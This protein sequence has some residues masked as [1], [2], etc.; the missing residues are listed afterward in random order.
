MNT[1]KHRITFQKRLKMVKYITATL[2]V[3][4]VLTLASLTLAQ[5]DYYRTLS[6]NKRAK[7]IYVTASRGEIRDRNGLLLAGNKP[8]FTVQ[9]MKDEIDLKTKDE[10]NLAMT[11]LIHVLENDA[12]KYLNDFNIVLN[13]YEY[14][15]NSDYLKTDTSPFD[16]IVSIVQENELLPRILDKYYFSETDSGRFL[17]LPVKNAINALEFKS[18]EVPV[19]VDFDGGKVV[20]SFKE[21]VNLN[22][23]FKDHFMSPD[24][25]PKEV[26]IQLINEDQI[27]IIKKMMEHPITR[28]LIYEI[29]SESGLQENIVLTQYSYLFEQ[30]YLSA[31][32]TFMKANSEISMNSTAEQDFAVMFRKN[33]FKNLLIKDIGEEQDVI[34]VE[35]L[36]KIL[37]HDKLA[38]K[39]NFENASGVVVLTNEEEGIYDTEA[40]IDEIINITLHNNK[41][42]EFL[43][44]TGIPALAQSQMIEDGINTKISIANGY[45]YT[46]INGLNQ[47]L[48]DNKV[49]SGT[50][51]QDAFAQV[52][53]KY[54]LDES[55]SRYE[56]LG[57]LSIYNE[58][59]KQG[60]LAYV[61]INFA[62]GLK[63]ETVAK[64]E[65]QFSYFSGFN[66][67][68]EPVRYY[69]N[70]K[71][72]SHVLG[73]IGKISQSSEIE[74][75]VNQ[76]GYLPNALIGKTGIE[77]SFEKELNGTSGRKVVEVDSIGNT[78]QIL[79]ETQP[80]PGNNVYLSIDL[81]L[82]E[83]TEKILE[84]NLKT[85]Q[86][87]G[88]YYSEWGDYQVTTSK[89]KGR[90]YVNATSGAVIA[91]DVETGQVLSMA[92][93]PSYD[94]NLFAMGISNADWESLIPEDELNPLAPRPL[95]NVVTQTAI[96]PGS[97]FKMVTAL[98]ALEK[99]LSP[100]TT[101]DDAG[102]VEIGD[103]TFNCWLYKQQQQFHGR[104]NLYGALRD[105]CNYYFYT[106]ALGENQ[107]TGEKIEVKLEIEDITKTASDLGLGEK[108][109]M[110]I[111][112]PAE[113]ASGVPNPTTKTETTKSM[114]RRWLDNN[115]SKYYIGI[116]EFT[117]EKKQTLVNEI[118]G[119]IDL[120]YE[121]TRSEVV[122]DLMAMELEPEKRLGGLSEGL[123]DRIKFSYLN[124]AKWTIADTLNITIGQGENAYTLA[125][126]GNY[127]ATIANGGYKH[128]LSLI[129]NIK[130][131]NNSKTIHEQT[132]NSE[133]IDV[134][135]SNN[136]NHLMKG[137]HLASKSGLNKQV[138][139]DFP[140]DVGIKTGT[141]EKSGTNPI[142]GDTY[143]SYSYQVGFAPYDDPKIAVAVV[144]FQ[145]GD[146]S[147]C[148]PIVRDVIAEYMGLTKTEE[149][150][151]LPI[152]ME[153]TE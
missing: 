8:M 142:T 85:V 102:Y 80:I 44:L 78:T 131:Y 71:V 41:L 14:E 49:E 117:D 23:W 52:V 89:M 114:L 59:N 64:I 83:A 138:Y 152:E 97:T 48:K 82:Q 4:L 28:G 10:K 33:S 57:V 73:Y 146:G 112:I 12:V 45:E 103:H 115:I 15:D 47:W 65:E 30:E 106:L 5:G 7:N 100:E 3:I 36:L 34:P 123:A 21:D 77:E 116:E 42:E 74:T 56:K 121:L 54:D 76:R 35:E 27:T 50:S 109:G 140:I 141:A 136:F 38:E 70:G 90:P 137:M 104:E 95:Y 107:R 98:A 134:K 128:K 125:Q 149:T 127:V 81:K 17:Y 16:R 2:M 143:D 130:N 26:L 105:S 145:G 135:D 40:L 92:S 111:Y 25:P 13:S 108:T 58:I 68:V 72:A 110:E 93:Y 151:V 120:D 37:K 129:S 99:G 148:S 39:I 60:H 150:D 139:S 67:S 9:L 22:L 1:M 88:I 86:S 51:A 29:V 43:S 113:A 133:K 66:I 101:I 122:N 32:R 91:I 24:L 18:V 53:K 144:M 69:P 153:I 46:S 62:Y 6:T 118:V 87:G 11:K 119:W 19:K 55:L 147:N 75:Y 124:Q 94:P 79:E 61:P 84:R 63:N 96:Q 126:L 31:K 132:P 20:Y